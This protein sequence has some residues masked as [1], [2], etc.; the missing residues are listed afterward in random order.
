M[1][2]HTPNGVFEKDYWFSKGSN[3]EKP[4][5]CVLSSTNGA[6]RGMAHHMS[7]KGGKAVE[8]RSVFEFIVKIK[9]T[10]VETEGRKEASDSAANKSDFSSYFPYFLLVTYF[11][12]RYSTCRGLRA[13]GR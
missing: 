3:F 1:I 7:E 8:C 2:G 11:L 12:A 13:R 4:R 9:K 10:K 5:A 6:L